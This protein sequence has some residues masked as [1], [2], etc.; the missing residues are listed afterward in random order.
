MS[1]ELKVSDHLIGA[2]D[3]T[4]EDCIKRANSKATTSSY[5]GNLLDNK[6]LRRVIF[7]VNELSRP[8]EPKTKIAEKTAELACAE[9]DK[10]YAYKIFSHYKAHKEPVEKQCTALEYFQR[11]A[12]LICDEVKK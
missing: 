5:S 6:D 10:E 2:H 3:I 8:T 7:L 1:N 11:E 9:L 4:L 12:R